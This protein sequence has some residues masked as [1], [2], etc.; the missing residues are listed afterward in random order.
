LIGAVLAEIASARESSD[1]SIFMRNW[2]EHLTPLLAQ[3]E[4]S[5]SSG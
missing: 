5:P 3:E 1:W 2:K 4:L